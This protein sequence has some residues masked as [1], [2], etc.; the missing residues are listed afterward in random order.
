MIGT[1][2]GKEVEDRDLSSLRTTP[3]HPHMSYRPLIRQLPRLSSRSTSIRSYASA[4]MESDLNTTYTPE[5]RAELEE[6]V[7]DVLAE[8]KA[9]SQDISPF[10]PVNTPRAT[11]I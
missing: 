3:I 9:A 10:K 6:N 4:K 2:A 5:R 7:A 11:L 1:Q 8:I